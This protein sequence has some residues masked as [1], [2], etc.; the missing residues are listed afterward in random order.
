[1]TEAL[2]RTAPS[3]TCRKGASASCAFLRP[4]SHSPTFASASWMI[5]LAKIFS[6]RSLICVLADC[7]LSWHCFTRGSSF[8]MASLANPWERDCDSR[9]REVV[10]VEICASCT[11]SSASLTILSDSFAS[12]A[13]SIPS[14]SR[15]ATASIALATFSSVSFSFFSASSSNRFTARRCSTEVKS[16][17]CL[18]TSDCAVLNRVWN[19]MSSVLISTEASF[20]FASICRAVTNL[21]TSMSASFA[22][23]SQTVVFSLAS[24]ISSGESSMSF[25]S[26]A[27]MLA[28]SLTVS[29]SFSALATRDSASRTSA[30]RFLLFTPLFNSIRRL[31]ATSSC[32]WKSVNFWVA[33]E[34]GPLENLFTSKVFIWM[35]MRAIDDAVCAPA[36]N[37]S[38]AFTV[39]SVSSKEI[40]SPSWRRDSLSSSLP[41][42]SVTAC[43]LSDASSR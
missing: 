30:M 32:F 24:R 28:A 6:D 8:D 17:L 21:R 38:D 25:A 33:S 2:S 41:R 40:S 4:A 18:A 19:L 20:P 37:C 27:K 16:F 1:M 10:L 29:T 22:S 31:V 7:T 42:A 39:A 13:G 43:T 23:F 26:S 35:N 5:L 12:S 36:A 15:P 11:A 3:S 9:N 34:D 14:P